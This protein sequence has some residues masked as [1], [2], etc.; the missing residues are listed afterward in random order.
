MLLKSKLGI[1][2][3]LKYS[4]GAVR[5]VLSFDNLSL[6]D[7][8]LPPIEEQ[9]KILKHFDQIVEYRKMILNEE[10]SVKDGIESC[11]GIKESEVVIEA[12]DLGSDAETDA[13]E[14]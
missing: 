11:W 2:Q 9:D 10:H 4:D 14:D 1:K 8:P 7:V 6:I 13:D 3:I 12:D 5:K